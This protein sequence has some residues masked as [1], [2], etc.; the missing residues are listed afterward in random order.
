[1]L[2]IYLT[3]LLFVTLTSCSFNKICLH[4]DKL[5]KVEKTVFQQNGDTAIMYFTGSNYQP[6]IKDT[7]GEIKP[8]KYTIES[9]FIKSKSGNSIYGWFLKPKDVKPEITI[10]F[11]HGNGGNVL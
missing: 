11:L 9:T 8:L 6:V 5:Q 10:L 1:M 2:R 7:K 4:P 3:I